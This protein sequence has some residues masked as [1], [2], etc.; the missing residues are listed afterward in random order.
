MTDGQFLVFMLVIL[1]LV[2]LV[3]GVPVYVWI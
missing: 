3:I 1:A 2:A